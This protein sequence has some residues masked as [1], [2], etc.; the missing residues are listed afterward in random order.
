[1]FVLV[2]DGMLLSEGNL[3]WH[4]QTS[5]LSVLEYHISKGKFS[6]CVMAPSEWTPSVNVVQEIPVAAYSMPGF[7][8]VGRVACRHPIAVSLFLPALSVFNFERTLWDCGQLWPYIRMGSFGMC[9]R[10]GC[11][12]M[13]DGV[14]TSP[15]IPSTC[16]QKAILSLLNILVIASH[17][18]YVAIANPMLVWSISCLT[19]GSYLWNCVRMADDFT[20]AENWQSNGCRCISHVY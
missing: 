18:I 1:M 10:R 14:T 13:A 5:T 11:N 8:T 15:S 12:V 19:I 9:L 4:S 6:L 7:N 2:T 16:A 17:Q 3:P 20:K